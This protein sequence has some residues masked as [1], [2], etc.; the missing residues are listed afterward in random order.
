VETA[1][2]RLEAKR[3][4]LESELHTL[5]QDLLK[6]A[7]P[8]QQLV[9][10][11]EE[12]RSGRETLAKL[13]AERR[14]V[15]L[16]ELH[17]KV[18]EN[19]MRR[20]ELA[21]LRDEAA[22]LAGASRIPATAEADLREIVVRYEEAQHGLQALEQR[23]REQQVK[24]QAEFESELHGLA[25]YSQCTPEDADRC[26]GLA[27]ELQR[28]MNEDSRLRDEAF[29]LRDALAGQGHMPDR[30]QFL[31]GKFG[32]L[33]EEQQRTIRGQSDLAL[34]YQTEVADLEAARTEATE[35]LRE[36]D[37]ERHG[38]RLP[39]W[40]LTALGFGTAVAG[41]VLL[42]LHMQVTLWVGLLASGAVAMLVGAPLLVAGASARAEDREAA[43]K[44]LSDA[45]RRLNQL[46]ARRAEGEVSIGELSRALGYRDAVSWTRARR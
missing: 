7:G 20:R 11:A 1:I 13:D 2:Q 26:V 38:K 36:I 45:Q 44:R 3:G 40:V 27:S 41:I 34:A 9:S 18:D 33:T 6:I 23:R 35:T 25:R 8:T 15:Q 19:D 21:K 46:R 28:I 32:D 10:L 31:T 22:S 5:E 30:I 12:E 29:H 14:G 42:V 39:G 16:A 43:L 17:R 4:V 37:A 24:K